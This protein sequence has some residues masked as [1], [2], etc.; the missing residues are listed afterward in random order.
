MRT[1][2]PKQAD[3]RACRSN[4]LKYWEVETMKSKWLKIGAAVLSS[5]MVLSAAAVG[6][7]SVS[8]AEEIEITPSKAFSY[9]VSTASEYVRLMREMTGSAEEGSKAAAAAKN[10]VSAVDNSL[11]DYF[12]DIHSQG[13]IGS[14]AAWGSVYY[15]FTH[16]MN[17]FLGR[18]TTP[19]NTF[20]PLFIYNLEKGG[21]NGGSTAEKA[22]EYLSVVGCAT[23][24]T[25][26]DYNKNYVT[27]NPSSEVWHE[28][29][30]YRLSGFFHFVNLGDDYT[31]ITSPDDPD[32]D[33]LKTMLRNGHI[34]CFSGHISGFSYSRLKACSD[35]AINREKVDEWVV[36]ATPNSLGGHVMTIVGYDD[37]IWT[38]INDNG[39]IDS[40]E[41]GALKM[42][43]SWGNWKNA[44]FCWIAYDA[45]NRYSVVPG[46]EDAGSRVP[47]CDDICTPVITKGKA[48]NIY[49]KYTLNSCNRKDSYL[50]V[51]ATRKSDGQTYFVKTIP[52]FTKGTASGEV[53]NYEGGTG[54][55]DGTFVIDLDTVVPDL[56]SDNFNE[57][58][59]S[60]D[61][62]DGNDGAAVTV[63]EAVVIDGNAG[64]T[65]DFK[66]TFPV[67]VNY[68]TKNIK[69]M[70]VYQ[71]SY[72][73]YSPKANIIANEPMK[74]VFKTENEVRNDTKLKYRV[75]IFR[76]Q[77]SVYSLTTSSAKV[78]ADAQTATVSFKWTPKIAGTYQLK[79]TACDAAGAVAERSASF[80][81]YSQKLAVRSI[82][83]ETNNPFGSSYLVNYETLKLTPKVTGGKAPYTY[84][85][86][87]TKGG[88]TYSMAQS[89]KKTSW[90]RTFG[91]NSGV[92]TFNVTVT[93]AEGNTATL[94]KKITVGKTK[95][96]ALGMPVKQLAVGVKA[97]IKAHIVDLPESIKEDVSYQAVFTDPSG[98]TTE[99][100]FNVKESRINWT[101]T[102]SGQH[103]ISFRILYRDKALAEY[104]DTIEVA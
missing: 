55:G 8:A 78:D 60:V 2:R 26:P 32:L 83:F 66:G 44:G 39:Q 40:G 97:S 34:A 59:W 81:V 98:K 96:T 41:M 52:N 85:Y 87:Y 77:K 64:R 19:E 17:R 72:L 86:S 88:K 10:Y 76:G 80:K 42:A 43:N 54:Y 38:D 14:C 61:I 30:N 22:F 74:I 20:N 51:K 27:Q 53:L 28:A 57:Y 4:I 104:N 25:V 63:K 47:T 65:Y 6:S 45:L 82:A 91:A 69:L 89:T 9:R 13:S 102:V 84:S 5:A 67:K 11:D 50:K 79:V 99:G 33:A 23:L 70:P 56:N 31:R 95:I 94:S 36:T 71:I 58:N 103:Q 18:K 1:N 101:P 48:S 21:V 75:S 93:D 92:Y 68:A 24:K 35:P 62:V 46:M 7:V 49:L 12:P 29:S 37:N 3:R 15:T 90:T 100:S 16:E 73:S